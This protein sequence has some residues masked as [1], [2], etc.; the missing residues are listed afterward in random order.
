MMKKIL[1]CCTLLTLILIGCST[2]GQNTEETFQET[3]QN[4]DEQK[5]ATTSESKEITLPDNELQRLDEGDDV[6]QL[7]LALIALGYPIDET[8]K[9]DEKTT[10]AITD[11]QLREDSV[12]INGIYN[13]EMQNMI[14]ELLTNGDTISTP[15]E[16]A[17]PEEPDVQ[18]DIVE[19]PYE[20]LSIVNKRFSLPSDYEPEDLTE[21]DV[22]FPF[23]DDDPKKQLR[24]EAAHALESLFA[25]ADQD[26]IQL[27]AQSG[28]RSYDRQEAIFAA[29]VERDGETHANTYSAR[30]GESEHQTGLVMDV[31]SDVVNYDLITDFGETD[32]GK[33]VN[34]HAHKYGFIIRYPEGKEEITE[35]QYEPWHLRYVGIKAATEI[36]ENELTLEEYLHIK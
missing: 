36:K 24:E 8:G 17:E 25:A 9:Y 15:Y 10:W 13:S 20:I 31:T 34:E 6:L 19:N 1:F 2:N 28:F 3:N 35:Y 27:Y 26:S 4:D 16:L 29:N 11:L 14:D 30:P 12:Y 21:P 5:D 32:E 18:T 23:T 7:Q 22:P 33:W